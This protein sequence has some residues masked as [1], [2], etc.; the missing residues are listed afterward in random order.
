MAQQQRTG[1]PNDPI[2]EAFKEDLNPNP[3]AGQNDGPG[4]IEPGRF[5]QTADDIE[6]LHSRLGKLEK[7]AL[8]AIPILKPGTRLQQGATYID[9]SK[10]SVEEFT[11]MGDMS[12]E[13]N[14][15]IVPKDRVDYRL[16]NRLTEL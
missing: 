7:Q 2:G 3:K 15:Y 11:G 1:Y 10:S 13:E 12:V 4:T 14:G 5:E 8:Q 16:W 6:A 9:L